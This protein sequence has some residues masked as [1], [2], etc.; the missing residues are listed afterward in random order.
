MAENKKKKGAYRISSFDDS[1]VYK[2]SKEKTVTISNNAWE[3]SE[4]HLNLFAE[5][6]TEL[7]QVEPIKSDNGLNRLDKY[8]N[9]SE[10]EKLLLKVF[11]VC[12][13]NPS[14]YLPT[15]C[16]KGESASGKTFLSRMLK[17]IVDPTT[18]A[19]FVANSLTPSDLIV[20]LSNGYF[21]VFD[22]V[23]KLSPKRKDMFYMAIIKASICRKKYNK[24]EHIHFDNRL[25]FTGN[26]QFLEYADISERTLSFTMKSLDKNRVEKSTLCNDFNADLPFILGGI[27]DLL[28]T[29]LDIHQYINLENL[30]RLADF[31]K[32]GYA[33]AEAMGGYGDNFTDILK[34]HIETHIKGLI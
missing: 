3:V 7:P 5:R 30:I 19:N 26:P 9:I 1:I 27:F 28:A 14:I 25:C 11:L 29:A 12:C 20:L 15:I 2:L 24:E 10:D 16:I 6:P 4:N 22:D 32:F 13:F 33:V 21:E 34:N 8:L 17:T 31:H 18:Y 23:Y